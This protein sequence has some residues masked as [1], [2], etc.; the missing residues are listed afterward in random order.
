MKQLYNIT[1]KILLVVNIDPNIQE[2]DSSFSIYKDD[3]YTWFDL[4]TLTLSENVIS[5]VFE[6]FYVLDNDFNKSNYSFVYDAIHIVYDH[7]ID[8]N[9]N[10]ESNHIICS[11]LNEK[12]NKQIETIVDLG[13]ATGFAYKNCKFDKFDI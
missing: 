10:F 13:C 11:I 8:Q 4:S 2:I 9:R 12:Y 3:T 6:K 1:N 7:I 5:R